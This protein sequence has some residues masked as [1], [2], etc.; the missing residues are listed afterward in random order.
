[1]KEI[2]VNAN[3]VIIWLG[4][5]DDVAFESLNRLND[6]LVKR[7]NEGLT[8]GLGWHL[9]KG[10]RIRSGGGQWNVLGHIEYD[11]LERLLAREWFRRACIVQEVRRAQ[12]ATVMCGSR[13]R[14]CE[15]FA[16][17]FMIMGDHSLMMNRRYGD[18][19]QRSCENIAVMEGARR[20][21]NGPLSLSLFNVLFATNV[22]E[23]EKT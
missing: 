15:V 14:S 7:S 9:G 22:N 1:M 23:C 8:L 10:G 6:D 17:V 11:Q 16:N 21:H 13:E 3:K 20:C 5:E 18:L 12:E 19:S 2:Y 4:E